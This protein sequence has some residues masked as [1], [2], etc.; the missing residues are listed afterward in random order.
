MDPRQLPDP[1]DTVRLGGHAD[2]WGA[3]S[4]CPT[5]LHPAALPEIEIEDGLLS[6]IGSMKQHEANFGLFVMVTALTVLR[7]G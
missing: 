1:V 6:N 7:F 5:F 4:I 2:N 3:E